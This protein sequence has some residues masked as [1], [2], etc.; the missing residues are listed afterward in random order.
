MDPT[1]R[2]QISPAALNNILQTNILCVRSHVGETLN[3][4]RQRNGY[5]TEAANVSYDSRKAAGI[6]VFVGG[7]QFVL[8]MLIA[9]TLHPGY[10]VA[11][12]YISDL[13]V[14]P[15]A[16]VFNSSAFLLGLMVVGGAY[17]AHRTFHNR[18]VTSLLVLSG[19]GA[20]GVGIFPE[21]IPVMHEI[22]SVVA[23]ISGGLAPIAACK[24]QKKPLNYL[25]IVMGLFSLSALILLSAQ[26]TFGLGEQYFLGLGPGGIERM[27][28]YPILL[29]ETTFGGYLI[30]SS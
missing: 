29:W 1:G 20:M 21:D 19:I 8:G 23:F 30:G 11:Q 26:Y 14:G 18:L 17:F 4:Q 5:E 22:V 15:A 9:E 13:G 3:H 7:A 28:V 24:L 6:L 12:N 2:V 27:I 25:S 10:S 16:A